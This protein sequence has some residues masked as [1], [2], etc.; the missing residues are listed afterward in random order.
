MRANLERSAQPPDPESNDGRVSSRIDV[1]EALA[2]VSAEDRAILLLRYQEGLNY[3]AIAEI[4]GC[5]A[6]TVASRLSRA[7]ERIKEL[8]KRGYDLADE[9]T[10]AAHPIMN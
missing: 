9:N 1:A 7:R 4:T 2:T 6:G 5:P 8:L 3:Q 10:L